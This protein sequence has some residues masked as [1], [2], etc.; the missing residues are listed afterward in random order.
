MSSKHNINFFIAILILVILPVGM[1]FF[2]KSGQDQII[3]LKRF[4][5]LEEDIT[6]NTKYHHIPDFELISQ[7]GDSFGLKDLKGKIFIAD[8]FFTRCPSICPKM[9]TNLE[10]VQE[11]LEKL[12]DV[13]IV[14]FSIDPERDSVSVLAKYAAKYHADNDWWKFLTGDKVLIYD[15]AEK[16]FKLSTQEGKGGVP[17]DFTHSDRFVLVDKEGV[18]RGIYHGTD[19]KE[20]ERLIAE[21]MILTR[22]YRIKEKNAKEGL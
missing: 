18:I 3:E 8:F 5:P 21:S 9:S 2:L 13:M 14:S 12:E 16:G 11:K 15:L 1:F 10:K 20:I 6:E 19:A 4:F 17:E 7:T 22:S